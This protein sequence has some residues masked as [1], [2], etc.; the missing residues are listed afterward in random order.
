M[1]ALRFFLLIFALLILHATAARAAIQ[2]DVFLGYDELVPEASWFPVVCE[3]KNDGPAFTGVVEVSAG[4]FNE[5]QTHRLVV[6]LPTGT[7]KRVVIP[8][9]S[10]ARYQSTWDVRLL[11]ERGRVH[12]D[13]SGKQPRRALGSGATLVGAMARTATGIPELRAV[14][15]GDA[16]LQPATARLQTAIFPDNPISLEGMNVIY[17]NSEKATE[18]N[19]QQVAALEAWLNLGGHLI[20]GIEAITDVNAVPWLRQLVPCDLTGMRSVQNHPELE[21]WLHDSPLP[22]SLHPLG[23]NIPTDFNPYSDVREDTAFE[24]S[25][26]QVAVGAIRGGKELVSADGTPL[27]LVSHQGRGRVTALMFSPERKPFSIWN[28]LPS[29]WSRITEVSPDLYFGDNSGKNMINSRG[30]WSIDGVFGAMIDSKQ[31]RKLPV[32]WLLLLLIV[33][34]VVIGPLDQYW[35]KRIKRPMLTW[36]TFPCYVVFFSLLIYFI[37]YKLRAGETEWNELHIVDV[38]VNGDGAELRGH[39][40]ASI[41]SPVNANYRVATQ[42]HFSTFRDEFQSSFVGGGEGSERSDVLQMGD[43]FRADISVPVWTSQLFESDW[44]Q[45]EDLP[46][47]LSVT[48]NGSDSTVVINN[49]RD[50]DLSNAKLAV[51]DHIIDVGNLPAGQARTIHISAGQGMPIGNFVSGQA[52]N[53]MNAAQSRQRAFGGN[54]GHITDLPDSTEAVSFLSRTSGERFLCPP[55]L[56]LSA[57]L[58]QGNAVLLAWDANYS[59]I[60]PLNQF[61]ARRSQKNTL[62]RISVP[63]NAGSAQ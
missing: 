17:L 49:L 37:G 29:F 12:A 34:L 21:K 2:F 43:N 9:F 5:N 63:I 20:I 28:N 53:F 45:H 13:Q 23:R 61:S 3:I 7:L 6:E 39:S 11:D 44:W 47:K 32:E 50:R 59:P 1:A 52:G 62:W 42:E 15:V 14:H 46:L 51:G 19:D 33:Y 54:G 31:V 16:E 8:V 18:L 36:V 4:R 57:L 40:Y 56:D 38:L 60:P 10:S 35:L 48:S 41:Y 30:G 24:S 27:I 26:L 22:P 25:P 58:T 55:G